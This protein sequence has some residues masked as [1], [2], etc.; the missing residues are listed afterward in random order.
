MDTVVV[1]VVM[2]L[3]ALRLSSIG[4][5]TRGWA[6]VF[7]GGSWELAYLIGNNCQNRRNELEQ[8]AETYLRRT[9]RPRN[10]VSKA[11]A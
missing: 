6:I 2:Y 9:Y 11:K 3:L 8:T 1:V 7:R 5:L 4:R 10:S